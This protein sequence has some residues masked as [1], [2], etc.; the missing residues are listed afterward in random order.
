MHDHL[1]VAHDDRSTSG[2][3]AGEQEGDRPSRTR[4]VYL[5]LSKRNFDIPRRSLAE[6]VHTHDGVRQ[7][8]ALLH[9]VRVV[10]DLA[11]LCS[12]LWHR[13]KKMA[14]RRERRQ[15]GASSVLVLSF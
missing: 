4:S 7:E 9:V 8:L 14:K 13:V 5:A 12:L 3:S 6:A 11:V 10:S 15:S 1:G 2:L